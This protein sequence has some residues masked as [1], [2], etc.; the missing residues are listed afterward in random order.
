M[1]NSPDIFIAADMP[2]LMQAAATRILAVYREAIAAHGLFHVA[3]SGGNTPNALFR[4][5]SSPPFVAQFDWARVHLWWSDERYVALDSPELNFNMANQA[6]VSHISIPAENVHRVRVELPAKDAATDYENTINQLVQPS[7]R[8]SPPA[9]DLILLGLGDDGHTA[10]LFPGT[11][12][13]IPV[14]RLV[15]AHFV[16]KVNMLRITFTPRLINAARHVMFL[17]SGA[18][19]AGILNRVINGPYQPDMLPSQLIAPPNGELT[20]LLDRDAADS[21]F[22]FKKEVKL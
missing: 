4:L 16:P 13:S 6:L 2:A 21:N 8:T 10:S 1:C 19:K 15:I 22:E 5:L 11:V 17:V 3:L 14:V 7:A 12:A 20:W 9:Y 18:N